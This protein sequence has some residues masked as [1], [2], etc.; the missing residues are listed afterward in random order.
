MDNI[1]Q[2][3]KSSFIELFLYIPGISSSL[4]SIQFGTSF[5]TD[6]HSFLVGLLGCLL[7]TQVVKKLNVV[8]RSLRDDYGTEGDDPDACVNKLRRSYVTAH[9]LLILYLG[10][11]S[12]FKFLDTGNFLSGSL[13]A[14]TPAN[15]K[16]ILL[17]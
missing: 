2:G 7:L 14:F 13:A 1:S 3:M 4:D 5:L 8:E 9:K 15:F 6:V 12:C 11:N 10:N 16:F 17:L